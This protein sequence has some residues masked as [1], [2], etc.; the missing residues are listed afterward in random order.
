MSE[1][2]TRLQAQRNRLGY[3]FSEWAKLVRAVSKVATSDWDGDTYTALMDQINDYAEKRE[4]YG[5]WNGVIAELI[6]GADEVLGR[7]EAEQYAAEMAASGADELMQGPDPDD[8]YS[9][10]EWL[11]EAPYGVKKDGT[12]KAK[13]GPKPKNSHGTG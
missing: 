4:Q 9:Q 2:L 10:I 7:A 13:P 8:K 3:G 6:G 11:H 12:P 5:Y 1:K